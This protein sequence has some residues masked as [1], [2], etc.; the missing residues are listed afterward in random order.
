[1]LSSPGTAASGCC[2]V[3]FIPPFLPPFASS[4]IYQIQV[5]AAQMGGQRGAKEIE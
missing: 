1:M 3:S 4:G 2:A 5:S